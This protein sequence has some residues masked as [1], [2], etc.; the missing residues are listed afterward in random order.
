MSEEVPEHRASRGAGVAGAVVLSVAGA[1]LVLLLFTIIVPWCYS[2]HAWVVGLDIW[3]PLAGAQYVANGAIFHLYEP[4]AGRGVIGYPY[5]PGLPIVFAPI[6]WLGQRYGLTDSSQ[7]VIMRPTLFLL[8]APA[9]A[10]LGCLPLL[11]SVRGV[12]EA[13]RRTDLWKIQLAVFLA[14]AWASIVFYHPED[15]IVC[16][17]L[18]F[19]IGAF[20]KEAWRPLGLAIAVALLFKQWAVFPAL[21]LLVAVPRRARVVVWFYA[22]AVPA[23]VMVP[24]LLSSHGTWTSLTGSQ[25]S[26]TIGQ[27]QLWT[28]AVLGSHSLAGASQLR[29]VWG[30]LS[31]AIA[32]RVRTRPTVDALLAAMGAVMVAR[33][34]LEPT[35]FAY[36]LAPAGVFAVVWAARNGRAVMLRAMTVVALGAW[37]MP[38]LLTRPLWWTV[39]VT[40]LAYVCGPMVASILGPRARRATPRAIAEPVLAA[41]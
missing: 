10:L 18:L 19:G 9:T 33:L 13:V 23:L 22:L 11:A 5:T 31:V 14:A 8:M 29:L 40:G 35:I 3:T 4:A 21:P 39:L 20:R 6:A 15:T 17:A 28:R 36:Y 32:W 37:C 7:V 24:F 16:A 12:V 34:F 26:I 38:H 2:A 27:P 1:G 41:A 25:A 30:L